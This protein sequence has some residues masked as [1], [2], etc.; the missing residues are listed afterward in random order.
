MFK[1]LRQVVDLYV[2]WRDILYALGIKY[3]ERRTGVLVALCP[4]HSERTPSAHFWPEGRFF[5]H[6]CHDCGDKVSFICRVHFGLDFTSQIFDFLRS[7]PRA[8]LPGQLR[9]PFQ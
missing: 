1:E 6:G 3:T 4:F 9:L 7:M 2:P 5:C 8:P